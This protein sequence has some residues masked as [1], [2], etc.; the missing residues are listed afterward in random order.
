[1]ANTNAR[2]ARYLQRWWDAQLQGGTYPSDWQR[3]RDAS[4]LASEFRRDAQFAVAQAAF[5]HR[6]PGKDTAREVVDRLV[7]AP[8]E[9]DAELL[10]EAVVR[11]GATAQKVRATTLLGGIVTVFAL[12]LRNILRGR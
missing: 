6:R 8:T 4:A 12:V 7:P 3:G 9:S 10:V 2:F 11:A 1:M 5:L